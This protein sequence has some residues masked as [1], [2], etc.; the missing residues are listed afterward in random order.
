VKVFFFSGP[1]VTSGTGT[2]TV[3]NADGTGAF[4]GT[5]Q[6]YFFYDQIV[7]TAQV[8]SAKPWQFAVPSTVVTF[9]F[10]V[11]VDAATPQERTVLRW[12]YDPTGD[13]AA[14]GEVWGASPSDVFV[15]G[16]GGKILHYNGTAWSSF[17]N[18][19]AVTFALLTAGGIHTCGLTSGG[20]AYCWGANS[21]GELGNN[22]TTDSPIPVAVTGSLVFTSVSA[23]HGTGTGQTQT[24]GVTSAGAAYCWGYNG[25]GQLGNNT[26]TDSPIPVAVAGG[27]L[28]S[29]VSSGQ[30]H[31]CGLTTA[32]AAYCWGGNGR[33]QLGNNTTTDSPVPVAVGGSLTFSSISSGNEHTC[34][35]ISGGV[36]YCWGR[37]DEGELGT[38]NTTGSTAPIAVAGS[39]RKAGNARPE[40]RCQCSRVTNAS[41]AR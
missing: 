34:G 31:T 33:G 3:A 5:S 7:P 1:T 40:P 23:G 26:T 24:C 12:L 8:S 28:F 13:G 35:L 10:Q 38:N 36:V 4:T 14:N 15:V 41:N 11:L 37:N 18:P 39:S 16:D 9:T 22:S 21:T 19:T 27:L 29:S 20:T 30:F 25:N 6:P 2:V 32:G 17:G